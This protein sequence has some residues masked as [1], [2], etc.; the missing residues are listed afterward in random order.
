M[1]KLLTT[2]LLSAIVLLFTITT[3]PVFAD[4]VYPPGTTAYNPDNGHYYEFWYIP[5]G[6]TWD[7]ASI[8]AE[9]FTHN[10]T[11]GRLATITDASENAFVA[12]LVPNNATAWIGLTDRNTEGDFKWINGESYNYTNWDTSQ[13][14][15]S[16]NKDYVEIN[17]LN[18]KWNDSTNHNGH[19]SGYVIEYDTILH[20]PVYNT[21]NGHYYR[22]IDAPATLWTDAYD[23]AENHIYYGLNGHLVTITSQSENDFVAGLIPNNTK[24]WIGLYDAETEG[25]YKWVTGESYNYTNWDTSQPD[26]SNNKDYVEINGLNGKWNDSTNHNGHTS[27]YVIEYS[28]SYPP[29]YPPP[30]NSDIESH[31]QS[32]YQFVYS[33]G[34]TWTEAHDIAVSS[35]YSVFRGHLVTIDDQEENDFLTGLLSNNTRA[36]IGLYDVTT[37][38]DYKWVTDETFSYT[39]WD[40]SQPSNS[41]G[42]NYVEFYGDSGKWNDNTNNSTDIDGYIIEYRTQSIITAGTYPNGHGYQFVYSPGITYT[43]AKTAAESSTYNGAS[44][45]LVTITGATENYYVSLLY[46]YDFHAWIG[47]SD[48]TT[49]GDYTWVTGEPFTYSNWNTGQ[50]S[51]GTGEN[52]VE[53]NGSNNK[54]NDTVNNAT[55]ILGYVVE[56]TPSSNSAITYH[57]VSDYQFIYSY[58]ISWTDAKEAA[59]A[60]RFDGKRGHLATITS[61]SENDFLTGLIP[62]NSH[63]WIGLTDETTEGT[64]QW[65]TGETFDY[66]NWNTGE[67]SAGADED[68][69]E[70]FGSNGKWN[71]S[72]N[73][74]G[75]TNGYIVEYNIGNFDVPVRYPGTGNYY[76]FVVDP[77]ISWTVAN[78][79]AANSVHNGLNGH[80]ATITSQIE[81]NYLNVLYPFDFRAW[82]GLSDVTTEG[83][84]QWVTGEMYNYTNWDVGQPDNHNNNEDYVEFIKSS[85]KWNDNVNNATGI[86]GYIIEYTS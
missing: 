44:G 78:A 2:I 37:E 11:W 56:Y 38:G 68:Y 12:N 32:Y 16:N 54:W 70:F 52:Y 6:T 47:L 66:S 63:P 53:F 64:Y 36:W 82:I 17:G 62:D 25:D 49:E 21:E 51:A 10:G 75:H 72:K 30:S 3:A 84:Y 23:M 57:G 4:P 69:I 86:L 24:A 71:D 14:D 46:P 13:P 45:H 34:I 41:T 18:G 22:L 15:N 55:D 20:D 76:H 31:F 27:V 79:T 39:N 43:D 59:E 9:R 19:T 42:E 35:T 50:P 61:Q 80:L 33:P 81:N 73:H 5:P 1:S 8:G 83:T 48:E 77:N 29:P 65:V 58:D 28:S 85:G 26:N 7:T 74:N 67:P 40:T 60:S